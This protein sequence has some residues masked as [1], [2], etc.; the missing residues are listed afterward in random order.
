[1]IKATWS[2]ND[3]FWPLLVVTS[4]RMKT[5]TLGLSKFQNDLFKEYGQLTS[6]VLISIIPILI[7]FIF[8]NRNI[9]TGLMS[10][11]IKG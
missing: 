1:V 4:E 6:A 3:F 7:V 10:A 9:K 11:G 2:W 5:I 8:F